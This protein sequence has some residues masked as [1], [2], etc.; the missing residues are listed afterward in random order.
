MTKNEMI[1]AINDIFEFYEK[2]VK[3]LLLNMSLDEFEYQ[4]IL[5]DLSALSENDLHGNV[6]RFLGR[7]FP[8]LSKETV[9]WM[10]PFY[11]KECLQSDS[12]VDSLETSRL[13]ITLNPSESF[14]DER[15]KTFFL[16]NNQQLLFLLKFLDWFKNCEFWLD[17]W[18]SEINEAKKFV[19]T[20]LE[21][22]G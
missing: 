17:Y 11:L 12:E 1:T 21:E 16:L 8:I 19:E 3:E 20:M 7:C 6:I 4:E 2:P 14:R 22:R 18:G 13:I 15:K 10:M 9:R 5:D